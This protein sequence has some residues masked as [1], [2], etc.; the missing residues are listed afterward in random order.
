MLSPQECYKKVYEDL[1][2]YNTALGYMVVKSHDEYKEYQ[3][4]CAEIDKKYRGELE[5]AEQPI[6]RVKAFVN[7]AKA[8]TSNLI[9]SEKPIP[10]DTGALARLQ[11]QIGSG[12]ND[13][14]AAKL[15]TEAT[16]QLLYLEQKKDEIR[17]AL[18]RFL[19]VG[20]RSSTDHL[21]K[22]ISSQIGGQR[23]VDLRR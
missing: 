18:D 7:I 1:S 20:R 23:S 5:K 12:S 4:K 3:D 19:A 11:V 15:Y 2:K 21:F 8:R 22:E 6:L 9:K 16:G 13:P 14:L 10:F 17:I